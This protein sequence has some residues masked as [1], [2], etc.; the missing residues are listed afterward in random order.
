M[1]NHLIKLAFHLLVVAIY[2]VFLKHCNR[3]NDELNA[4]YQGREE[5]MGQWKYLTHLNVALQTALFALFGIDDI[6]EIV[7]NPKG[8]ARRAVGILKDF[9]FST[10][11]FPVG[12]FVSVSFWG[13]YAIDRDLVFPDELDQFFPPITNHMMHTTPVVS[14]LIELCMYPHQY[15]PKEAGYIMIVIFMAIYYSIIHMAHKYTGVWVYGLFDAISA[16]QRYL[17]VALFTLLTIAFY[18]AGDAVNTMLFPR[19]SSDAKAKKQ[20]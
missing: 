17:V 20:K 1:F 19:Y 3:V 14:L 13:L 6:L 11:G 18:L 2:V 8:D 9:V 10:I 12:V 5:F 15:L 7:G 4:K 16:S